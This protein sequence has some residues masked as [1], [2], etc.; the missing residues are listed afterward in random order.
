[1]TSPTVISIQLHHT[2]GQPL[3]PVQEARALVQRGF[4]GDSHSRYR[5]GS[6]RQVVMLDESTLTPFGLQP[7]D[8][9]E[10]ITIRGIPDITRTPR[11]TRLEIGEVVF[12]SAGECEPCTTIGAYLSV[13]D[14]EAFQA[15]LK[16]RR[17]L[18][19]RVVE[20]RGEGWVRMGDT[21]RVLEPAV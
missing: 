13:E 15:E 6:R 10:Q 21:V 12:E 11:G 2:E 9:R 16:H 5:P 7:G 14:P 20:V 8:L 18:L 1:M 17:G 3:R 19:C 4:E